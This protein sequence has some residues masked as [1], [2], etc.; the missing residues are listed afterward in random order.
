MLTTDLDPKETE[1]WL[2]ALKDVTRYN[3]LE[4]ANF[5]VSKLIDHLQNKGADLKGVLSTPYKNT[6]FPSMDQDPTYRYPGDLNLEAKIGAV[7][8]WNAMAMV[9]KANQLDPDLGG[10]IATYA[11]IADLYEVGFH[12]FWQA[13]T[14][15]HPGDLVFFQGHSS[16]GIYARSF[17]EGVLDGIDLLG[18]RQEVARTSRHE[19]S[20]SSSRG[21]LSSYPH[22]WLMPDYWQFPTVS[23]GLGPIQA[24]YLARFM[25]YLLARNLVA[26]PAL[27]S[28]RK[29]WC[30]CGDG[31]MDEP[32]STSALSFAQQEG[33]NNLI[34][35]VN[36]N[37]QR[38][39]GPVRGNG[40]IVQELEST[41]KGAGWKV[42]KVIWG[43]A[44]DRLFQNDR[45]GWILKRVSEIVDGDYQRYQAKDGA[46]LRAHLFGQSPELLDMVADWSDE[47]LEQLGRGGHD[48]QKIYTAYK[49]A[50]LHTEGPVVILAKTVKGYG[51]G[52]AG[53]SQNIAHNVKKISLDHLK[54]FRDR[55]KLDEISDA[56]IGSIP[57]IR[58]EQDSEMGAYIQQRR[59]A[60]GGFLPKRRIQADETLKIPAVETLQPFM[61]GSEGRQ[62]STTMLFV[63][64]LNQLCKDPHMGSRIVPIVPDEAR[65]FG[66][67]GLF[68]QL[69][70]YIPQDQAY[71]PV[72][73]EQVMFYKESKNGQILQEGLNEAGAM[74]SWLAAATAYSHSNV[75]M[76][77]F[78]IYYS[79]F[80]FQRIGD[81]AWAAGDSRAR[82]FLMGATAGRTT[83][84]GEGLQH[85]DGHSHLLAHTIPNCV[86]YDPCFGYELAVIIQHGLE[87]M[88]VRQESIFFYITLMNEN[89][90]H[91]ALNHL[92]KEGIVKGLYLFK[93]QNKEASGKKHVQLLGSGTIFREVMM[94]ADLLEQDWGV[95]SD[96]WA[97]TSFNEL[98]KEARSAERFNLLHPDQAPQSA[99]VSQC[100]NQKKA[101]VIAATDYIRNYAEPLRAFLS[102]PYTVLGTDGF[103]RSDSRTALRS[104]FEVNRYYVVVAALKALSDQGIIKSS[105]VVKAIQKYG[106]DPDKP[107]PTEV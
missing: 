70:I 83:L 15:E 28:K 77:P 45:K 93:G 33:L 92:D 94:A 31:E 42:I 49:T 80:G 16:P 86:S 5:L 103:G 106:L 34:F 4:R 104:F 61:A 102:N 6:L 107:N 50:L 76:I 30:F 60:L 9:V 10:H 68:R 98:I 90:E 12:H 74:A 37:L 21:G 29:I 78:Y 32:E 3:G 73:A 97:A 38:L 35:V 71:Q 81:L 75:T 36:C 79:M 47:E 87:R 105:T 48:L 53:E 63:R 11:S 7:I 82:G 84:N 44:W 101:P 88:Y 66:M 91:P 62:L 56:D 25:K 89:Y 55:F 95:T 18:F 72:D 64:I 85:E 40:K 52:L 13:E 23:M 67:E 59:A 69:G 1:E 51:L 19:K 41:F 8:R 39:D 65:T 22:P 100:L 27:F 57:F 96:I 20:L 46:Y 99:Y 14:Q 54:A 17:V 26:S 24:I 43:S 58:P 2:L